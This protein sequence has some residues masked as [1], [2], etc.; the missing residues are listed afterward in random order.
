MAS[1]NRMPKEDRQSP[2]TGAAAIVGAVTMQVEMR[3]VGALTANP[4]NSR[5]HSAAQVKQIRA[6]IR[7]FGFTIPILVDE[8]DVIIAGHGRLEGAK[9]EGMAEVP[10]L[11]ARGWSEAQKRAYIIADNKLTLNGDWDDAIL[12]A[13]LAALEG[14][15]FNLEITGFS[16]AEL[17]KML[18]VDAEGL[19]DGDH[20]PEAGGM[21]VAVRGDVWLL[22]R[23]RLVCGDA[24]LA[25]DVDK[26]L[27]GAKPHL[28]V[29]DPPYGVDYDPAWRDEKQPRAKGKR[30]TGAVAN[31]DQADWG[32]AWGLFPGDVVYVWHAALF[33]SV[34]QGSLEAHSFEIRAQ[35]IWDKERLVLG[36]GDYQWQHEAAWYAVKKGRVGHFEGDRKQTTVWSIPLPSK[37]ETGHGTQKPLELMRRC[38]LN[39]SQAGQGVYEPFSGSGT[40]I[41]ACERTSRVCHALEI[42]PAHVDRAILR[43]QQDTGLAAKLE[44]TGQT[45]VEV[46]AARTPD[47][48]IGLA[49]HKEA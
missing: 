40:T 32:E 24:T 33:S 48:A 30:S 27:A 20:V 1:R 19:V 43:W 4:H 5:K 3:A 47:A 36:R 44:E 8:V 34:V 49:D 14:M 10:V 18:H 16:D 42:D 29:T 2:R 38:V 12:K 6:S 11:V 31:D 7:E 41:V 45:F 46:M 37:S 23:H 17:K 35:I 28:M 21:I 22:G 15:D 25:D 39:N 9:G 13:E 26:A